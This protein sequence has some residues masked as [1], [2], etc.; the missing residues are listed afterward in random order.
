ME[1]IGRHGDDGVY[2]DHRLECRAGVHK[3]HRA[4]GRLEYTR[5]SGLNSAWSIQGSQDRGP[6]MEHGPGEW[7]TSTTMLW[8]NGRCRMM[9]RMEKLL[10]LKGS[11]QIY[12]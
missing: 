1:Y 2:K 12:I 5:I 3:Y 7:D 9:G 8:A 10:T 4:G 11:F 6:M